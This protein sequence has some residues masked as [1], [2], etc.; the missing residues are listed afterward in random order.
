MLGGLYPEEYPRYKQNVPRWLP[1][2][3]PWKASEN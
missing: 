1:R 3:T 2:L